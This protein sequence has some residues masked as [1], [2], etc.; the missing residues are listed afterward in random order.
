MLAAPSSTGSR[1]RVLAV[2][3]GEMDTAMHAAAVPDA[4][5]AALQ[6]PAAVAATIVAMIGDAV[7]APNGAR[8]VAPRWVRDG[9][10]VASAKAVGS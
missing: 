6:R 8:L 2:D 5:R 10:A 4:D 1:V 9:G 7:R 3:P